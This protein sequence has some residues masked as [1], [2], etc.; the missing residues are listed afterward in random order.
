MSDERRLEQM[1]RY[2]LFAIALLHLVCLV[3]SNYKAHEPAVTAM[4]HFA[5]TAPTV[6][7]SAH[8]A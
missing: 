7:P 8:A 3:L 6:Q 4:S 1:F 5:S 2:C